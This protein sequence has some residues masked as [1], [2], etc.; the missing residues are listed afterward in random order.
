MFTID[1][2]LGTA[3]PPRSHPLRIAGVALAFALVALALVLDDVYYSSLNRQ[4][5]AEHRALQQF[6]RA[7]RQALPLVSG[8]DGVRIISQRQQQMEGRD[9][10]YYVVECRLKP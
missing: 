1:L 9:F 10:E 2:L 8:P 5:A 4:L 3:K 6:V 7:L